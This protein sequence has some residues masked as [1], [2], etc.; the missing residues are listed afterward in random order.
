LSKYKG[1]CW[2]S[3]SNKWRALITIDGNNT[4]LG[5][6]INEDEGAGKYDEAAALIGRPLNFPGEGQLEAVKGSREGSTR[7]AGVSWYSRSNNWRA[8]IR[9]DGKRTYL[10][11]FT[12]KD[13]AAWKYDEAAALI[14]RSLKIPGEG[15]IETVKG[16]RGGS[17]GYAG[18]S[19]N[20]QSNNWHVQISIDGKRTHLDSFEDKAEAA[21]EYDETAAP[22]GMQRNFPDELAMS[23]SRNPA[24]VAA[25]I[26]INRKR[27]HLGYFDDKNEAASKCHGKNEAATITK[28]LFNVTEAKSPAVRAHKK[29]RARLKVIGLLREFNR[30]CENIVC[31]HIGWTSRY[32]GVC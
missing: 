9:I 12:N 24:M 16:G 5:Y 13:E 25:V 28:E 20:S 3:Q 30:S 27:T 15:Q 1:V 6:F 18:V 31:I 21:H 14:G 19:W 29:Q 2:N 10:G 32:T 17:S 4:H 11:S 26:R 7:Y 8:H 23:V 22:L